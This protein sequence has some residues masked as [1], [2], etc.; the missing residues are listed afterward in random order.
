MA[1]LVFEVRP[2]NLM[3]NFLIMKFFM[4]EKDEHQLLKYYLASLN[5]L[6]EALH[7]PSLEEL[8]L[9]DYLD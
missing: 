3:S 4:K 7:Q 5:S 2:T 6:I 1:S 9:P 8:I